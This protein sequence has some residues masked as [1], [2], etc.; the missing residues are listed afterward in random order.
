MK[1]LLTSQMI[2]NQS[3]ADAL[4]SL[5]EKPFSE[6]TVAYIVTSHN[7]ARGDKSWFVQNLNS[8]YDLGWK[9]HLRA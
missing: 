7:G 1:L 2:Y 5:L 9:K 6:A 4:S 3:I 8:V